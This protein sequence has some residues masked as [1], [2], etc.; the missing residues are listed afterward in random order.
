MLN[1]NRIRQVHKMTIVEGRRMIE[2][3]WKEVGDDSEI[4][5]F[6][7]TIHSGWYPV[8][9]IFHLLGAVTGQI[10]HMICDVH[11]EVR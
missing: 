9:V 6:Y 4:P 11:K 7:K 5:G 1:R 8:E 3:A 10:W 2:H